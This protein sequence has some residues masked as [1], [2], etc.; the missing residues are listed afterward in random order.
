MAKSQ[1]LPDAYP[2]L[3]QELKRRIR[4][5]QLRASVSV[6]RELVLLYWRIGRDILA[7]QER[8]RWGAKVIDRLAA[9]LK[10]AFPEMKG[11]SPRNLKYMRAFAESWPDEE[12]VQAVLAQITW[13]HNL[14]LIEKL[15]AEPDRVWYAKATIQHAWSRNVLVHQ[16]ETGLHQRTG[17][18]VTN[19]Q[20]TLPAPQSDLAQEITKDPYTFDFLMLAEDARERELE[21][22]LLAHL[23]N[24]LLELGIGFAFVG[25]Q[26]RI[27]VGGREFLLDLLFF[28]LKL[29]CFVVIDLKAKAF[30]PEF[31]GK[32]NFIFQRSTTSS[33]TRMISRV[34]A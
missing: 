1:S 5:S 32:M 26:Y 20:K 4:E 22:G 13:Y 15:A 11:F 17:A 9:D 19:F 18:A 6:N 12:F 10:N 2:A 21:R 23:K 8:E 31:A 27:D 14:T 33:G 24:F 29:R 25:S 7:R 30:E 34:L 28:H 3:L 16:I